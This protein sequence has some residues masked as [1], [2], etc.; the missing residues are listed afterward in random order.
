MRKGGPPAM[1]IESFWHKNDLAARR[2]QRASSSALGSVLLGGLILLATGLAHGQGPESFSE[3]T[4]AA[5][6]PVNSIY[7]LDS[8][9]GWI[10]VSVGGQPILLQTTNGGNSWTRITVTRSF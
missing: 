3:P 8:K 1:R 6:H 9:H 10:S 5:K 2:E 7:F 4:P